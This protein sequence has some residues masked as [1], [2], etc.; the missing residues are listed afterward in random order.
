MGE[1]GALL[2]YILRL[3]FQ[4][5]CL[6]PCLRGRSLA[7]PSFMFTNVYSRSVESA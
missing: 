6:K 5:A 2:H 1:C 4:A 3:P 7:L